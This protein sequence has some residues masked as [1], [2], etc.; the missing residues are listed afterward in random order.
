MSRALTGNDKY[1]QNIWIPNPPDR[2]SPIPISNCTPKMIKHRRKAWMISK[3]L[4][5]MRTRWLGVNNSITASTPM[6]AFSLTATAEPRRASHTKEKVE[7]SS[8]HASGSW[9]TNRNNTCMTVTTH[10]MPK[11]IHMLTFSKIETD[12]P[13]RD[14]IAMC[15][16]PGEGDESRNSLLAAF[17]PAFI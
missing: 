12:L 4:R 16:I 5:T 6:C 15:N 11:S 14:M 17:P 7:S 8:V 10:M 3:L 9:R 13:T 1:T 2:W